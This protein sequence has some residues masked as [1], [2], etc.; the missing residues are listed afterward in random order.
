MSTPTKTVLAQLLSQSASA[1]KQASLSV[2]LCACLG[3]LAGAAQADTPR[4]NDA[5]FSYYANN[6][7]VSRVLLDFAHNFNLRLDYGDSD[8]GLTSGMTIG[9]AS[10]EAGRST[11]APLTGRVNGR[12]NSANPT[13]FL[14]QLGSVY[15]FS[16]F[17][18]AGVLYI[19]GSGDVVTRVVD[20]RGGSIGRLQQALGALGVLD[21]RFGWGEMPERGIALVSGPRKYVELIQQIVAQLPSSAG[22]QEV[23]VFRLKHASVLDRT[24][25]YRDRSIVTPGVATTLRELIQGDGTSTNSANN[26]TLSSISAPLRNNPPQMRNLGAYDGGGGNG[27]GLPPLPALGPSL[28]GDVS[29]NAGGGG[30]GANGAL[31]GATSGGM[32]GGTNGGT[33]GT[34]N[35]STGGAN[36]AA[37]QAAGPGATSRTIQPSVQADPRLNAVIVEDVPDRM[38]IYQKLID[39][40]DVPTA[41]VQIQ[42]QIIDV[43]SD[44]IR[45]LGINW[46]ARL[47]RVGF[48]FGD[49][50]SVAG[51]SRSGVISALNNS[52]N[53]GAAL[54]ANAGNAFAAKIQALEDDGD[55]RVVA[56]PSIL[57]S[58]NLGAVLDLS[59]T[60]YVQ[61]QG[62]RVATVTPVS[63]GTTL[64]VTPR[65]V[66]GNPLGEIELTVDIEDGAIL[67]ARVNGLPVV[68]KSSI[69]TQAR[70]SE[71]E[72]LVIAGYN[73]TDQRLNMISTPFLS[74]IPV[75]GALFRSRGSSDKRTERLFVIFPTMIDVPPPPVYDGKEANH[76]APVN[77]PIRSTGA[78]QSDDA[79]AGRDARSAAALANAE[80]AMR[81][82]VGA[83][84]ADQ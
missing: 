51:A 8:N 81:A 41:L 52:T 18:Y 13:D 27:G 25:R 46:S 71:N 22:A 72:A 21:P 58:D 11:K 7:P 12:F 56:S 83:R 3:V 34:M 60:F 54:V 20:A 61:T 42:A 43:S 35:A 70:I 37:A 73:S 50:S 82:R 28:M 55:A 78:M 19:S 63:V 38:P 69:G 76:V 74:K 6:A 32:N 77:V 79:N 68:R 24:I 45:D 39:Q 75:L 64:N 47:G 44:H 26:E 36:G 31:S 9:E 66:P 33:N 67:P 65:Y 16:W 84:S 62:E 1:T 15:G 53:G 23:R 14:D 30:S 48:G 5:P 49:T 29:G 4:W 40:L 10:R 2:L 17:T 57:T 80:A 59:D